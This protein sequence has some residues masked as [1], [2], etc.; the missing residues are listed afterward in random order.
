M[1]WTV[2]MRASWMSYL[3]RMALAMDPRLLVVQNAHKTKF[4]FDAHNNNLGVVL[5]RVRGDDLLGA[6]INDGL[7]A[8]PTSLGS[9]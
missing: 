7:G 4:G 5:G 8:H 3:S 2:V 1:A 6:A 9:R